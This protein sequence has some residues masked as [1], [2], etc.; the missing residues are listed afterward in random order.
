MNTNLGGCGGRGVKQEQ[1]FTVLPP[2]PGNQDPSSDFPIMC[3]PQTLL[4]HVT[5]VFCVLI[6][7]ALV[8]FIALKGQRMSSLL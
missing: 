7:N 4:K 3:Q 6:A 5:L 8:Q 2:P 1:I